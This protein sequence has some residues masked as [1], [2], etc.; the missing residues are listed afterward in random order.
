MRTSFPLTIRRI[1]PIAIDGLQAISRRTFVEAFAKDNTPENIAHYLEKNLSMDRLLEEMNTPG[2]LFFFG[3]WNGEL[4]GYLK[5]NIASDQS[6]LELE[7]IYVD[8]AYYGT[9]AGQA[10]L[11]KVFELAREKCIPE[12]WLGVWEHNPRAIRFYEKNGFAPYGAHVFKLGNDEQR[13]VLM[14]ITL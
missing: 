6:A 12:I 13:D 10:L 9:G 2:T 3:E 14:R 5:V 1:D 7:R 4:I 11:T 8:Q